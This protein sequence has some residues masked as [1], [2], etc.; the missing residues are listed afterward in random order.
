MNSSDG[1]RACWHSAR[2][3][4]DICQ[5]PLSPPV[6]KVHQAQRRASSV[7]H[8]IIPELKGSLHAAEW[9]AEGSMTHTPPLLADYESTFVLLLLLTNEER[10]TVAWVT[11]PE[12]V[13]VLIDVFEG[14]R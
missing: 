4:Q 6:Y 12:A 14:A 11:L 9:S 8:T 3:D 10:A 1:K 7:V 5:Q 13:H 2:K